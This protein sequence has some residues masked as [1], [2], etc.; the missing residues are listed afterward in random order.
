M[1][2]RTIEPLEI[3]LPDCE[4]HVHEY[5]EPNVAAEVSRICAIAPDLLRAVPNIRMP[6]HSMRG[7]EV[8]H[9]TERAR[10]IPWGNL[11]NPDRNTRNERRHV[12]V[13]HWHALTSAG[14]SQQFGRSGIFFRFVPDGFIHKCPVS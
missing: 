14:W 10:P 12:A 8:A 9:V 2:W 1:E 13:I 6:F 4:T 5:R 11:Y 7:L 3:S